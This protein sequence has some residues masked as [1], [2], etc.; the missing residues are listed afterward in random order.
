MS[1]GLGG[2]GSGHGAAIGGQGIVGQAA[3]VGG[4][5]ADE[6]PGI[7]IAQRG[8]RMGEPVGA[9]AGGDGVDIGTGRPPQILPATC[10]QDRATD[11]LHRDDRP[12]LPGRV[13]LAELRRADGREGAAT[14]RPGRPAGVGPLSRVDHRARHPGDDAVDQLGEVGAEQQRGLATPRHPGDQDMAG[15]YPG[16]GAQHPERPGEVL[17]GNVVQGLRQARRLEIRQGQARIA[18]SRQQRRREARGQAPPE[19]LNISTAG[20]LAAVVLGRYRFP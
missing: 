4:K 13:G 5:A 17:Q 14:E 16:L 20:R 12:R 18:V 6:M 1:I 7:A 8:H 11:A 2:L 3:V 19:P 15:I 10:Q 9:Q